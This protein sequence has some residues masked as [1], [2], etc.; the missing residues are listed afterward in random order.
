LPT[1]ER[2]RNP[3]PG[4]GFPKRFR[5]WSKAGVEEERA[6]ISKGG[7]SILLGFL[8]SLPE[9]VV[10]RGGGSCRLEVFFKKRD[11]GIVFSM[12]EA[13]ACL[14]KV[15]PSHGKDRGKKTKDGY[16]DYET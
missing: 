7:L 12:R 4:I 8:K 1:G 13:V 16:E 11:S 6:P 15:I 14:L 2:G 10:S 5:G 3:K 9:F